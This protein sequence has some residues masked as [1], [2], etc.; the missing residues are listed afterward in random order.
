MLIFILHCKKC[1]VTLHLFWCSNYTN[2][3]I[4][5]CHQLSI[6]TIYNSH[7]QQQHWTYVNECCPEKLSIPSHRPMGIHGMSICPTYSYMCYTVY[8]VPWDLGIP[9]DDTCVPLSIPS[10]HETSG[11]HGTSICPTYRYMCPTVF[12][13]PD[14]HVCIGGIDGHPMESQ[15]PGDDGMGRTISGI[16]GHLWSEFT[17]P[18]TLTVYKT[19]LASPLKLVYRLRLDTKPFTCIHT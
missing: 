6:T 13:I 2:C 11:F 9:W 15:G 1:G 8:I 12:P 16:S 18:I 19:Y 3:P 17:F 7:S 5:F 10:S 4:L 14:T